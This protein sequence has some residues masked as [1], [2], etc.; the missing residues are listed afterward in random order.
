[1]VL[2]LNVTGIRID[3]FPSEVASDVLIFINC[4]FAQSVSH[5]TAHS[6]NSLFPAPVVPIQSIKPVSTFS[7]VP[8]ILILYF[9]DGKTSLL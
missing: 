8:L 9:P 3:I 5:Q 6:S 1:M 7:L 2:A 4:L